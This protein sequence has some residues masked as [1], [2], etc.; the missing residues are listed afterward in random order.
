LTDREI[1]HDSMRPPG[2]WDRGIGSLLGGCA[3][4]E[5]GIFKSSPA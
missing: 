3:R 4:F 5:A 1:L 2:S